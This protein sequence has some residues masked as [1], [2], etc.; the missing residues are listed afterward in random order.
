MSRAALLLVL[1]AAACVPEHGPT[2]R[3]GEDCISCH[4]GGTG[5]EP[6]KA[7]TLAGTVYPALDAEPEA[8]LEGAQVEV[9]DANEVSFTLRTNL[10]GNF[11]SS[12]A[13]AFPLKRL[14][15]AYG[16]DERCMTQAAQNGSCKA[17]GSTTTG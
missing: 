2:M 12:E 5:A 7:W 10:S 11:Y 16:G 8:G 14:C 3:P 13:L 15:I 1:A 4:G 17:P 9:T 6:A